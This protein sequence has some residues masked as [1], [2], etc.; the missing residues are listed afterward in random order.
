MN[1]QTVL[2]LASIVV[3]RKYCTIKTSY[4]EDCAWTTTFIVCVTNYAFCVDY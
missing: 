1:F 3:W 4:L 2:R